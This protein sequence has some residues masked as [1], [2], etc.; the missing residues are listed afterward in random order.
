VQ[1]YGQ[2]VTINK[3]HLL[4][5][6]LL[7]GSVLLMTYFVQLCVEQLL[8]AVGSKLLQDDQ[9]ADAAADTSAGRV[10][11]NSHTTNSFTFYTAQFHDIRPPP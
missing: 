9:K 5:L 10:Q 2:V 4:M 1:S 7:T 6:F 3:P 8:D 11:V